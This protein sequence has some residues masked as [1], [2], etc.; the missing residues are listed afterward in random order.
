[1]IT[2][3]ALP[4]PDTFVAFEQPPVAVKPIVPTYPEMA[5]KAGL[6][7]MVVIYALIDKEG[8]VRDAQVRKGLGGGLDEAA[9][10]AVKRT[11]FTPAIQNNRPV[12]VWMSIPIRFK[13][14]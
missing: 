12:A 4:P 7:G 9:L 5:R 10:E 2:D 1:M 8:R 11:P 3:E 6:E 13:L 14:R